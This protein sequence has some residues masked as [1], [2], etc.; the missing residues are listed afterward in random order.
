ME[1]NNFIPELFFSLIEQADKFAALDE[2]SWEAYYE[3]L[4]TAPSFIPELVAVIGP[5][6]F[7]LLVKNYGGRSITIPTADNILSIA[8]KNA[9]GQQ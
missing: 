8:R 3:S 9:S 4:N 7:E 2:A 1:D 6:A 5:G